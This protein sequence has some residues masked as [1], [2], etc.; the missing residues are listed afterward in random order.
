[1]RL[2]LSLLLSLLSIT[3]FSQKKNKPVVDSHYYP[4]KE[5]IHKKPEEVGMDAVKVKEA[6]EFAITH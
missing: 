5:W 4:G 1:M 3:A 6:I 2:F